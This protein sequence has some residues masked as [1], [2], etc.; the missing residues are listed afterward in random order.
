MSA[1]NNPRRLLE[2]AREEL[3]RTARSDLDRLSEQLQR[4]TGLEATSEYERSQSQKSLEELL[5]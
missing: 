3:R 5:A 4:F 1:R 2:S